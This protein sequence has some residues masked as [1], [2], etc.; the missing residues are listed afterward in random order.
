MRSAWPSGSR[1]A[2]C[3]N[4]SIDASES[5]WWHSAR[6]APPHVNTHI[7]A[8]CWW[9]SARNTH[10]H[11]HTIIR[12]M[13]DTHMHARSCSAHASAV[14][15]RCTLR[16]NVRCKLIH[17]NAVLFLTALL[18]TGTAGMQRLAFFAVIFACLCSFLCWFWHAV[19]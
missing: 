17:N 4:P 16:A 6:H 9:H 19:I 18:R 1:G 11:A 12:Q 3:Q 13:T 15:L 2:A 8:L 10:I 5:C 14:R 7:H